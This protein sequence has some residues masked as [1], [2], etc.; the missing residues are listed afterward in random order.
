MTTKTLRLSDRDLEAI[1]SFI[2]FKGMTFTDFARESMLRA[3]EDEI[4]IQA[5]NDYYQ[6]RGSDEYKMNDWDDAWKEIGI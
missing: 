3:I 2:H 6:N 5:V 4:D 1:E